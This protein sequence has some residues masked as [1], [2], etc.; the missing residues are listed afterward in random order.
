VTLH[1]GSAS[2]AGAC[3][4]ILADRG[5]TAVDGAA[6]VD[7]CNAHSWRL[8]DESTRG[9]LEARLEDPNEELQ[10]AAAKA[11]EHHKPSRGS[12]RSSAP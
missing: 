6:A 5:G 2:P 7:G 10:A 1:E 4:P 8:G 9:A 11:L 12:K 3:H